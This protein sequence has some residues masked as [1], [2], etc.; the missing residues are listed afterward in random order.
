MTDA[1]FAAACSTRHDSILALREAAEALEDGLGGR[2]PDLLVAFASRQL[3]V[4]TLN[5]CRIVYVFDE[6]E[7]DSAR[8]GFAY[9]TL[10][11]HAVAGEELFELT[12]DKITDRVS[13]RIAKFSRP[14][15]PLVW[16]AGPLATR[17]QERFTENALAR[18]AAVART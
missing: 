17:I 2:S 7:P 6:N 1:R 18:L 14:A 5:M 13:F 3:G 4:W 9:G 15:H 16:L 11:N 12:W 10:D 8:Y